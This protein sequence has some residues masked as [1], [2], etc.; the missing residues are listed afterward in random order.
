VHL[1]QVKMHFESKVYKELQQKFSAWVCLRELDFVATVSFRGYESIRRIEFNEEENSKYMRG[2]FKSRAELGRLS[3]KLEN[4]ATTLLPY[5]L[6]SNA[7]TFDVQIAV[8]WLLKKYGLWRYVRRGKMVTTAATVDGGEL[9]WKLTQI[10]AGIKI[11]DEKALDP[12]TGRL[13]FGESGHDGVQ[14]RSHCFPLVVHIAKDNSAFY[15]SHLSSFFQA[16]NT[17]EDT[18]STGLQF[19]HGAD[20]CSLQKTVRKGG[21]MKNVLFGCYCCNIHRD[22]LLKPNDFQCIDCLRL[23]KIGPCFHHEISD[24]GLMQHFAENTMTWGMIGL[25]LQSI[26]LRGAGFGVE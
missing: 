24:E 23:R 25:I 17:L 13:L 7:I 20:M 5:V 6:T 1:K 12:R 4:Y 19:T 3:R 16:I 11:C 21:A 26:L 15:D 9:A 22:N 10:S 18:Y 2:L 14:S 8:K